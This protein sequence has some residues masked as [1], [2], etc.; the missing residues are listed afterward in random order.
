MLLFYFFKHA[1]FHDY[2]IFNYI[3]KIRYGFKNYS[4]I[5]YTIYLEI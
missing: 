2:R 1:E 3:G 4:N 5:M